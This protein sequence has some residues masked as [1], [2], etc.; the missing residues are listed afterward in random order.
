MTRPVRRPE[1][2]IALRLPE[3]SACSRRALRRSSRPTKQGRAGI[4]PPG[5]ALLTLD[6]DG[7]FASAGLDRKCR[8]GSAAVRKIFRDAF[9]SAGL[10]YSNPHAFR[11]M[12]A[13]FG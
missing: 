9:E 10:P 1:P 3:P 11:N 5:S 8:R 6:A 4:L 2:P 13:R 12:L 7:Q